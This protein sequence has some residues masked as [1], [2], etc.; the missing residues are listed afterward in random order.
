MILFNVFLEFCNTRYL[1]LLCLFQ[2]QEQEVEREMEAEAERAEAEAEHGTLD[3]GEI[4]ELI[5]QLAVLGVT[6]A[7]IE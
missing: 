3:V 1:D 7:D 4:R 2:E 6:D 5:T